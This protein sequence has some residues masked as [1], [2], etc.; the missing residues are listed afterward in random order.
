MKHEYASGDVLAMTGASW[1]HNVICQNTAISL[2]SQLVDRDCTVVSSDMR[3]HIAV[4][5]AYRYPD[6][7]V[8]CG[9]PQFMGNRKDTIR[10]PMILIEVLSP[11]TAL[12]DRNEKLREYRQLPSLQEYL[13]I[14]QNEPR[15]ERFLRQEAGNWLYTEVVGLDDRI[16]LPSIA[17]ILALSEVYQKVAFESAG[18]ENVL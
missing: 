15:I 18:D 11:S 13:L 2:G 17:C 7:M 3:V 6:V 9:E 1:N 16:S 12:V 4:A 14:S 5:R 10:N 8:V